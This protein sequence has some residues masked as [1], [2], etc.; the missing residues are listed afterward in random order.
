MARRT[1]DST[2]PDSILDQL[3]AGNDP[4]ALFS[5]DGLVDQLKKR[6]AERALNAELDHHLEQE[7]EAGNHRNG[8]SRKTVLTDS[9]KLEI[10]VPRDRR[11]T[12]EPQLIAK[13]QRRF[14]GFDEK[15]VS[16]YARG[17]TTREI[18]G[19]LREIYGFDASPDLI[20]TITDAVLEEVAEWQSRPLDAL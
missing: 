9:A 11:S 19:H 17:L 14:P 1:N 18:Q 8:Y 7:D 12:F 6:L 16:M 20:S 13:Y 10:E 15:I 2:I 4:Q 5:K 3:L